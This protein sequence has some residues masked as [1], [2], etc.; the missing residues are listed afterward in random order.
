M[1]CQARAVDNC[2]SKLDAASDLPAMTNTWCSCWRRDLRGVVPSARS[3]VRMATHRTICTSRSQ[4]SA[5][6]LTVWQDTADQE[7]F[8]RAKQH[9]D[10]TSACSAVEK[11]STW[12]H[13][14]PKNLK[15]S[16]RRCEYQRNPMDVQQWFVLTL[17]PFKRV[18]E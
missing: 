5:D 10:F 16:A 13:N 6:S 3:T 15:K 18:E 1:L 11:A 9:G 8:G 4:A 12:F 14:G 7:L 2:R 17:L